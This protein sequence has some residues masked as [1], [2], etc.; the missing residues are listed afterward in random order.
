MSGGSSCF[1]T[2]EPKTLRDAKPAEMPVTK[3]T[4]FDLVPSGRSSHSPAL[5]MQSNYSLP[6]EIVATIHEGHLLRT[7]NWVTREGNVVVT[8]SVV[9]RMRGRPL[10]GHAG[11]FATGT[12][13]F[14]LQGG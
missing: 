4:K 1:S 5:I 11:C 9:S 14:S 2:V 10:P 12:A 3:A 8:N 7:G 6:I 13:I